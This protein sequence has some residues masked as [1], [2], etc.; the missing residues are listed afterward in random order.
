MENRLYELMNWPRIEALVYSEEDEPQEILGPHK[1]EEGI[2]VQAFLPTAVKVTAVIRG[3]GKEYAME[4][5]DE[6]GFFAALLPGKTVPE[7]F[8][9]VEYDNGAVQ[10]LEDAYRFQPKV[11]SEKDLDK[12]QAGIHYTLYEKMGA[13]PMTIKGVEGT[14]FAVWAPNACR[15]SVVGDFNLWDGRRHPMRRIEEAGIFELFVPGVGPGACYKYEIKTKSGLPMLKADP[16]ANAAELR[17]NTASVITDLSGFT[18]TDSSWMEKRKK[19]DYKTEPLL[20]YEVHLGSWRK[21]EQESADE[22]VTEAAREEETAAKAMETASAGESREFYNYREIAPMLAEYVKDMGYTHVELMPIMEHPLDESWGYQVTGY[23]A[24][25]SRYG[26]PKDFMYFMDYM[27]SQGIGVILDW[28]PAHFPRDAFGLAAFD[29]TC[30][31]EHL[32]PRQGS[33]PHWGTL[34][35][36]YGRPQVTNF[37]IAN[38]LYWTDVYH[39]DGIRMDAVASMLYLDYGKNDGEWVANIYGGKENLEAIEFLKHLNSIYKKRKD[40]ALLIAEES[41][42]WPKVTGS[43]EDDGLGFDFKWNMGWMNDFLG[44]MQYDPV[45]RSWHHGE[46]TFS[47]IYAYSENFILSLSHDEVV[48]GKATLVGKMPGDRDSKLNNLRAAYGLMMT[49][50]GKKLLFM[51]QEFATF[52]EWNEKKSLEWDL[53]QYQDHGNMRDY[54]KALNHFCLEHPALYQLDHDPE[55]FTWINNISANENMLVFVRRS[56]KPEETLLVV[57]NFSPLVY[58]K[59]KIGVPFEGRYKEIFNSD[60]EIFGGSDVLNRRAKRSKKSECD[61]LEN[62]IE[63]TV[64]PMGVT[65][66]SC[67]KE[68]APAKAKTPAREKAPVKKSSAGKKSVPEEVPVVKGKKGRGKKV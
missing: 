54:V 63:I 61:G 65:I 45:F 16:Y 34:I 11:F 60:S 2:L 28:V 33:H 6:G 37:L 19:T 56:K 21:P 44:Y 62:S 1:T 9:R 25:T 66:F 49:H 68:K 46:L 23:Y 31:Y 24:P 27:H 14:Y 13:H 43:V 40:G 4:L 12:F 7:Y 5:A 47:M 39:A 10:E 42:A 59:H 36:N 55:G 64:P 53:L 22:S 29:G 18:W 8:F 48:H 51:G 30:L 20:I 50:P 17:P 35:Y 38:A 3:T 26:S 41:T 52:D 15:V 57:C 67:T 58:E 32:D